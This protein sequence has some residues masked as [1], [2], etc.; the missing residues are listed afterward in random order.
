MLS[1]RFAFYYYQ[2]QQR[3]ISP[4]PILNI[5]YSHRHTLKQNKEVYCNH[6]GSSIGWDGACREDKTQLIMWGWLS[7][8]KIWRTYCS[9]EAPLALQI[10]AWGLLYMH[11]FLAEWQACKAHSSAKHLL[12][13][14]GKYQHIPTQLTQTIWILITGAEFKR[15]ADYRLAAWFSLK[16]RTQLILSSANQYH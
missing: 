11:S 12:Q 5:S 14:L 15:T 13:N 9:S 10:F 1:D 4:N 8:P 7:L 16:P 2:F 3:F 6:P